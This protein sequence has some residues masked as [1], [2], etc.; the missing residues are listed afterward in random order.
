MMCDLGMLCLCV[1]HAPASQTV[2]EWLSSIGKRADEH[3]TL[4]EQHMA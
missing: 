2:L 1:P 3:Q 4:V